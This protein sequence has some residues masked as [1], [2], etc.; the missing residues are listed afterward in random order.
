M[1][2]KMARDFYR[3][4]LDALKAAQIPVLIGGAFAQEYFTGVSRNTKD[5]DLF[6]MESRLKDALDALERR[7]YRTEV[8]FAHWLA[9]AY[10]HDAATFVDIIFNSGN[11]LCKVD[12]SWFK[13]APAGE[14]FNRPVKFCPLEETIWQK[15]FIME[16]ERYDGADVAHLLRAQSDRLDWHRL[17][18]RFGD[19][20]RVLLSYIVLFGYIY[21]AERSKIPEWV[22]SELAAMFA[23]EIGT[24]AAGESVCA[25]TFL[26]R[27]QFSVDVA[28]WGYR[29]LRTPELMSSEAVE[30]WTAAAVEESTTAR[31]VVNNQSTPTHARS[32]APKE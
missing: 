17:F 31:L 5:L 16:R 14:V 13:N 28:D 18:N 24:D 11:G 20:W 23:H 21:P 10:D 2:P 4:V 19:H 8:T 26:S 32:P 22:Q 9:K 25:G 3:N 12:E 7:G 27:A 1:S 6:L 30:R 15:A 29:D